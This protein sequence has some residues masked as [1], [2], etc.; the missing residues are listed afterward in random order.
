MTHLQMFIQIAFHLCNMLHWC[1]LCRLTKLN[2]EVCCGNCNFAYI[3]FWDSNFFKLPVRLRQ[4]TSTSAYVG[5]LG[6]GKVSII[7]R[8]FSSQRSIVLFQNG[9]FWGMQCLYSCWDERAPESV[10]L[11]TSSSLSI[12]LQALLRKHY[13][14]RVLTNFIYMV[15]LTIIDMVW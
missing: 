8:T 2:T 14:L 5:L 10:S 6:W 11:I 3:F 15:Y 7:L 1:T 4:N 12:L 9:I 13:V